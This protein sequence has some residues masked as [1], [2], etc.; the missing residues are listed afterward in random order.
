MTK[1]AVLDDYQGV[2]LQMAD[3][4]SLPDDIA[5]DVFQDHLSDEGDV[6]VR[7]AP[8]DIVVAMRERTPFQ[9]SL[10]DR[11]PNLRLLVTTGMRNASIDIAAAANRGVTVCGTDGVPYPT[12]E[13]TWGLILAL[14]RKIPTEDR[15]TR[16]GNWQVSIGEGLHGKTLGVIG[17]GRLGSQVATVGVAFGMNV[18]AWSQNL[19][20]ERAH[21]FG[22]TLVTKQELLESS[23]VVTIHVV[24]SGRTRGLLGAEEFYFNEAISIS[25]QHVARANRGRISPDRR[26]AT[27]DNCRGGPRRVRHR[28][29][30]LGPSAK[31]ASKH[32]PHATHGLR[33]RR[34]LPSLLRRRRRQHQGFP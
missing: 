10:L 14:L 5:V 11:L 2:A 20:A 15:A 19:T 22:A 13:L 23:D 24:L 7:L 21:E 16:D 1:V 34:D 28:A 4:D 17:L 29:P 6:A 32:S 8:Y 30:T 12:A 31:V 33:D 26:L 3:W 27:R 18:V 9:R 25:R